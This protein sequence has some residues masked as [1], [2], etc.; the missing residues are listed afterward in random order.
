M[1]KKKKTDLLSYLLLTLR[2]KKLAAIQPLAKSGPA[3]RK[4]RQKSSNAPST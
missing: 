4:L 3:G 2:M 1:K